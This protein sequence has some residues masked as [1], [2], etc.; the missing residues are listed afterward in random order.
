MNTL[1]IIEAHLYSGSSTD[2]QIFTNW[3]KTGEFIKP[4]ITTCDLG[5]KLEVN[6]VEGIITANT[7]DY[8]L[9]TSDNKFYVLPYKL[10]KK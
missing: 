10:F 1:E 4:G 9:K 6:T 8:I 3:I 5:R 7:G 2:V